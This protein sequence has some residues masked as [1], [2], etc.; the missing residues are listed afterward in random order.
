MKESEIAIDAS[1]SL[2]NKFGDDYK[3]T[4]TNSDNYV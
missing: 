1:I 3:N 2:N 4:I